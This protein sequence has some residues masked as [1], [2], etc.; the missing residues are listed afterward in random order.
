MS[1]YVLYPRL[2]TLSPH[3]P[4]SFSDS[5]PSATDWTRRR[6]LDRKVKASGGS[7]YPMLFVEIQQL[8][9]WPIYLMR[10]HHQMT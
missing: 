8:T 4:P 7:D 10:D 1:T 2:S 5:V 9:L 3:P 6:F